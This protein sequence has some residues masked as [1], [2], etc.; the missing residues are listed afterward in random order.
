MTLNFATFNY[1][2]PD[3]ELYQNSIGGSPLGGV[4]TNKYASKNNNLKKL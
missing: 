1:N 4:M 3:E 2:S